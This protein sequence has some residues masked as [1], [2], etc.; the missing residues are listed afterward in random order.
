MFSAQPAAQAVGQ[1]SDLLQEIL[2]HVGSTAGLL[3]C[4][5]VCRQW[6][7]LLASPSAQARVWKPLFNRFH[8]CLLLDEEAA[9]PTRLTWREAVLLAEAWTR[10]WPAASDMTFVD[11]PWSFTSDRPTEPTA[12]VGVIKPFPSCPVEVRLAGDALISYLKPFVSNKAFSARM[13]AQAGTETWSPLVSTSSTDTTFLGLMDA[14]GQHYL[15]PTSDLDCRIPLPAGT[16]I[17]WIEGNI[18]ITKAEEDGEAFA[19]KI[20]QAA[21]PSYI[22]KS[23]LTVPA[24]SARVLCFN[25]I[26]LGYLDDDGVQPDPHFRLIRLSDGHELASSTHQALANPPENAEYGRSRHIHLTHTHL[27]AY[28]ESVGHVFV[29]A[30]RDL[31]LRHVIE[32]PEMEFALG[33]DDYDEAIELG[34]QPTDEQAYPA[35]MEPPPSDG[36]ALYFALPMPDP[37]IVVLDPFARGLVRYGAPSGTGMPVRGNKNGVFVVRNTAGRGTEMVWVNLPDSF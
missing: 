20:E 25:N 33:D 1:S 11:K 32:L 18:C 2:A 10:P 19:W 30:L 36:S 6:R 5:A 35:C 23:L 34:L 3:T 9:K 24:A 16:K 28:S 8:A 29:F 26:V 21:A 4:E 15:A 22:L 14:A 31:A 17:S 27:F 13:D 12:A 7:S 37:T